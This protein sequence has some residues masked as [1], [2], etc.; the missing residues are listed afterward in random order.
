MAKKI[1]FIGAGSY[2]F[3]RNV[4]RDILTFPAFADCTIS[5][6]D[7]DE[8]KL[9]YAE[10]C[11]KGLVKARNLPVM[12]EAHMD[13]AKALEGADGIICALRVGDLDVWRKD[14][15]IP[16]KYG[17]DL[18]I[19]D[20]RGPAAIF[21]A[22]RTSPVLL[23]ICDDIKK[24]CPDAV[25]LNYTNPM[26]MLCRIMQ[27]GSV[28]VTGLCHSVW[29]TAQMLSRWIG[30]PFEEITYQCAGI[31]HQAWYLSY[32]WNGEDAIPLIRQAIEKPEIYEQDI[33][34]NEMFKHFGY[35]VTES[36]G[37]CSEYVP[38]FRKR[39]DLIDRYCLRGK[40]ENPGIHKL[41]VISYEQ[42]QSTWRNEF[43][44]FVRN[45]DLKRG[46]EY[47]A[48]IFNSV[49]GD[50]T[51]FRFN[52]NVRNYGLIDNL[53]YGSC[54]EVPVLASKNGLEPIRVGSIP[55]VVSAITN[56]NAICDELAAEGI[57]TGDPQKIYAACYCDPLTSAV[58]SLDEIHSM[59]REMF[60]VNSSFIPQFRHY[61]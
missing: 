7:I 32:E 44:D 23:S 48:Y 36:S 34:R 1:T 31:N 45:P 55:Q 58:L 25:F 57:M 8:E 28:N 33:V 3:T 56:Q 40:G 41:S 14:I 42:R 18:V 6:M 38:W 47:A 4:I 10:E 53:P 37:H 13:R 24:L 5:L 20:T 2:V 17:V 26:S 21:R 52:G 19:G 27:D 16:E 54:V 61:E 39:P 43:K 29:Q 12:V 46:N 9:F 15:E 51:L 35:Y 50:G 22:M 30:A 59:V 49:F 11:V 60:E